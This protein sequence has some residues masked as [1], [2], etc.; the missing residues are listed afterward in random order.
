MLRRCSGRLKSGSPTSDKLRV[1]VPVDI[2]PAGVAA[3]K[4]TLLQTQVATG[5]LRKT[6]DMQA[7][8]G[9]A[10]VQMMAQQ[11]GVGRQVNLTA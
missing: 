1:E 2:S 8:E 7:E 6:L 10:L 11:S 5:V 4:Q 9:A 3:M